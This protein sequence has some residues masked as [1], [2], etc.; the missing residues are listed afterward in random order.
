MERPRLEGWLAFRE[1]HLMHIIF[2]AG[3]RGRYIHFTFFSIVNGWA[4]ILFE[5][6]VLH[7][8][9]DTHTCHGTL[10]FVSGKS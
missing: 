3:P 8:F 10:L 6:E 7:S 9:I 2:V 5:V 1:G 4:L